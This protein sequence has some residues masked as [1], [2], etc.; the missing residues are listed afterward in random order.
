M[1]SCTHLSGRRWTAQHAQQGPGCNY[2]RNRQYVH[3]VVKE[4]INR[5]IPIS[6]QGG[7]Y[8][9]KYCTPPI[10]ASEYA[11]SPHNSAAWAI[12]H[13]E[14]ETKHAQHGQP[15]DFQSRRGRTAGE[16]CGGRPQLPAW[17]ALHLTSSV[18]FPD[19]TSFGRT[20][21]GPVALPP[22]GGKRARPCLPLRADSD[23]MANPGSG[24]RAAVGE[25]L[26]RTDSGD[27]SHAFQQSLADGSEAFLLSQSSL[28]A[29]SVA[30]LRTSV[31][32][33]DAAAWY[34]GNHGC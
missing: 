15:D 24:T 29:D 6:C 17:R 22:T 10:E 13:D 1:L 8:W 31:D 5:C 28:T 11:H 32:G 9:S 21:G 34:N 16:R 3:P 27:L 30:G 20:V 4:S 12:L 7:M 33:R 25:A 14:R 23:R 26:A 18:S 19:V 2:H